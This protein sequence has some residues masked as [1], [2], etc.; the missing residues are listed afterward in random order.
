MGDRPRPSSPDRES[1]IVVNWLLK[2]IFGLVI[3]GIIVME[4]IPLVLVRGTARDTASKAATEAGFTY[5]DTA[6]FDQSEDVAKQ[7]VED[8][9]AEFL[10]LDIDRE[11]GTVTVKL[12][13]KAKTLFIHQIEFLDRYTVTTA[14]ETSPI[15]G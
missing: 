6:D 13:K 8:D 14:T 15:P 11:A 10:S 5:R 1:G 12:R 2:L 4:I 3:V 9:G 7:Y